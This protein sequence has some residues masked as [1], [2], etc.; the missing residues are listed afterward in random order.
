M[1]KTELIDQVASASGLSKKDVAT[2]IDEVFDAVMAAVRSGEKVSIPGVIAFEQVERKARQGYNPQT[3][4][5]MPIPA[6]KAV[7]ITAGSRL[8]AAGKGA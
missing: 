7:K 2:V 6:S 3:G 8:K 1:N 4:E 5:P